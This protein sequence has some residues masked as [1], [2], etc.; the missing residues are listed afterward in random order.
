MSDSDARAARALAAVQDLL[1][2]DGVVT[3][4]LQGGRGPAQRAR[5][6]TWNAREG[7]ESTDLGAP[8]PGPDPPA[9]TGPRASH[10]PAGRAGR[11]R[12]ATG[13]GVGTR[14]SHRRPVPTVGGEGPVVGGDRLGRS[15][16]V[17]RAVVVEVSP[18]ER[19]PAGGHRPRRPTCCWSNGAAGGSKRP[20][21]DR[22]LTRQ[23]PT[24]NY[25]PTPTSPS[26]TGPATP[27]SW[28]P[29]PS[30]SVWP[31]WP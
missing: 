4:R 11:R 23:W 5:F 10:S 22:T 31:H 30:G 1:G 16:A 21:D 14:P 6:V 20:T 18:E 19:A 8:W 17:R 27:R 3:A 28:L 9:G 26:S 29:Q 25:T 7:T 2:P 24:P 12:R 15:V 13:V